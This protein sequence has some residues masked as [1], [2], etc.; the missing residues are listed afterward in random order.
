MVATFTSHAVIRRR[1]YVV[2][3]RDL[4]GEY[5][6]E[7]VTA[8]NRPEADQIVAVRDG[9]AHVYGSRLPPSLQ[10]LQFR[11]LRQSQIEEP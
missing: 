2:F 4:Q 7:R 1:P 5:Q 6:C 10:A 3:Y 11:L 8:L 9:V